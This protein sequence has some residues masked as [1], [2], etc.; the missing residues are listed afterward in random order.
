MK[1]FT[2]SLWLR[3]VASYLLVVVIAVLTTAVVSR[4][5]AGSFF[6]SHLRDMAGQPGMGM[7]G[8]VM[9]ESMA[10][11]LREGF[12]S[13]FERS[14]SIAVLVSGA[15]AL[16]ASSYAAV[17]VLR[18]IQRIRG[19]TRRLAGGAY[20]E[21]VPIPTETELSDLAHDVNALGRALEQVEERRVRLISEVAHELRTPL[22]TIQGYMEGLLDGVFEPTEEIFAV[23]AGEAARLKRLASDLS[24]LSAAE[25]GSFELRRTEL[26][27]GEVATKAAD[28]LRPQFDAQEVVLTVGGTDSL[29]IVGDPD[30]LMQVFTNII[31]NALTHCEPQGRVGVSWER[32]G[33]EARVRVADTGIGMTPEQLQFIFERF[34]R[35]DRHRHSGTGIGLTIARR[36]ARLHH[37]DVTAASE[38][39]GAGSTFTVTLPLAVGKD[40]GPPD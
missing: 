19:A 17:R 32:R 10:S 8:G 36:I 1:R 5:L 30:R 35:V 34:Y 15:V 21:R 37:G 3:L 11:S 40:A 31:G 28:R 26:D 6:E 12:S 24:A 39:L 18:P 27:L 4:S 25:E 22:S 14:V 7:S 38:G 9:T 20:E 23:T 16:I 29:P 2:R 33:H 13:S